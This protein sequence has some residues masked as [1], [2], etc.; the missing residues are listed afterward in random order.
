MFCFFNIQRKNNVW[1]RNLNVFM[2][3]TYILNSQL[4]FPYVADLRGY[5]K[6]FLQQFIATKKFTKLKFL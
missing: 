5:K 2:V 6:A 1:Q 4:H 3:A